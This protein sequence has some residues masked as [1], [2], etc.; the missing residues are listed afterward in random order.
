MIIRGLIRLL[1]YGVL[2]YL[3]WTVYRLITGAGRKKARRPDAKPRL[4]GTMVK[5][6]VCGIYLPKENALR[7]TLDGRE[8]FFCSKECRA[9]ALAGAKP[10]GATR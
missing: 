5:D 8:Q 7:E 9:K 3:A 6:D 10:P 2:A 4:S 1:Y